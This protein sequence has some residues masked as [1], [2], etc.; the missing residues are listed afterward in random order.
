MNSDVSFSANVIMKLKRTITPALDLKDSGKLTIWR[1]ERKT[2]VNH[3]GSL[4]K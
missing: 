2:S 4:L 3:T 1:A